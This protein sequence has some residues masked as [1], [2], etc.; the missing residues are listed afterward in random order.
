MYLIRNLPSL[1]KTNIQIPALGLCLIHLGI[2][3]A[4]S[5][6]C[7]PTTA[8]GRT[9]REMVDVPQ[10][11]AASDELIDPVYPGTA[12][13]RLQNVQKRVKSLTS[14]ELSQDWETVRR[15]ILWAGGLRDLPHARPG[16]GYTGHSF[17]DFNHCD[18][19]TMRGDEAD[20]NN[21]GRVEGIAYN[22]RLGEGIRIASIEELGPGGSWSTCMIGSNKEPPQDVAHIQF[23]SRI[24]F[25]L[26]W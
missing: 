13:T 19:T 3:V 26:V 5:D 16:K 1:W 24:A 6:S 23:K 8:N 15:S 22:N 11:N 18:L 25:K 9:S 12:V 4:R 7:A 2:F 20:N 17:N 10:V 14:E 21:E